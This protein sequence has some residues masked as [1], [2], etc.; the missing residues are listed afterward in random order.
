MKLLTTIEDIHKRC[1]E[2]IWTT[3][4]ILHVHAVL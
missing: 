2:F 1:I 4:M 3:V